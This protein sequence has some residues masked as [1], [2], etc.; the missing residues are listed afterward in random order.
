MKFAAL[1]TTALALLALLSAC[2]PQVEPPV[3]T[4]S[5]AAAEAR[6]TAVWA[7]EYSDI[8]V[9]P[10][11]HF[12]QLPNGMRYIL[13][14]N[15]TPR[16]T[17]LVR[18]AIRTGSLNE[19]ES[20][21]GF[22]HFVEHMAFNGSTNVSE[23]EMVRLLEREGLAFGADT[24][25]STSFET[26]I[27]KLDLPRNDPN[28][29]DTALM[30]MRETVSELTFSPEAVDRER[31][32]ILA[33]MRD[34]NSFHLRNTLDEVSFFYPEAH[35][36][37]RFPIGKA[38]TIRAATAEGLK[39][40]WTRE[41]VPQNTT[42]VVIGD[43]PP[44]MVEERIIEKFASWQPR[45]AEPQPGG[46]PVDFDDRARTDIYVDP[47]LSERVVA[48]RHGPWLDEPD[49][50]AQRK[51]NLLRQIGYN[52]INRRL[53][54]LA[55][56]ADPPFRGAG[57][58]TGNVFKDGRT[59]RLIVDSI[60]GKWQR[61]LPAAVREYRRALEFGFSDAE[62]AEQVA[63]VSAEIENNAASAGTR[64]NT[65][66]NHAAFALIDDETV[67]SDPRTVRER[68]EEFAPEIT[69]EA[70]FAALMRHA[71]P[72]DD[73][74][75]R[76]RGRQ[77]PDGGEDE[78]RATWDAAMRQPISQ[79]P[80]EE[81]AMFAYTD[82]GPAGAV[83]SDTHEPGLGIRKIRFANGVMLNLK[84]T[85][86]ENGRIRVKLNID[87]GRKLNTREQPLA[88]ELTPYLD[89]GGLG[90]HSEDELQSILAGKTVS[91][92][93]SA[94][95][96]RFVSSAITTPRDLE[97]QL[98]LMAA[99][100]IDPG[101]RREGEVQYWHRVNNY[102]KQRL[103]TPTAALGSEIGGI[104]SDNDPR[105]TLQDVQDYRKANYA[106]LKRAI[107]ERFTNGAI[108]IGI[109]G[110]F[111]EDRTIALVAATFGALP[112]REANFRTYN[113]QPPRTFT[114]DR[115]RRIVRHQGPVDQARLRISWPT[116]DGRDPL[117]AT[118]LALLE[119]V[120]RIRLTETLREALGKAY[121]PSASSSLSQSWEGFGTF[122]IN[123]SIDVDEVP[124]ARQAI[125]ETIIGLHAAPPTDDLLKR[126]RQPMLENYEQALKSNSGWLSLVDRAQ[127]E[128]ERI[129][130][131][132]SARQ[133][134][135]ALTAVDVQVM[136]LRYLH[137]DTALE[138]LVLPEEAMV[139]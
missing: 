88:T 66:L 2:A 122:S 35:Y 109:V 25:A 28:L 33:E 4:L 131:F 14:H 101:Y 38:E 118:R 48:S 70:A 75:L 130:R 84:R 110:D 90:K 27:Y 105:F 128:P 103:A 46:G 17:A 68:F 58:G 87:G 93:F 117:E 36:P 104:I 30:L 94:A 22:A 113:E 121:S 3:S 13:R 23:G 124:A 116:R 86:L 81:L 77:G 92:G 39:A 9:D 53:L 20:E 62:V 98:Q 32:V 129:A 72:L 6:K 136:A 137:L 45:P 18:M 85:D 10:A 49:T 42:I 107:S 41:Y 134:L 63:I 56:Q 73:P 11:Y 44:D 26:T 65:L 21:L 67:P 5:E 29:L 74:L 8:P 64:S 138:I 119:E 19:R 114:Q 31:G 102:F 61:A 123:A 95:V 112:Q 71:I 96:D 60:D 16:G 106:G 79:N 37:H 133:R 80:G 59:T 139:R 127:T 57:F 12:G 43:F 24:N 78:L 115:T 51:E 69:A 120:M 50:V 99:Y 132:L 76:F 100:V 83:V 54:H 1:S 135:L 126:A 97:L 34:R 47:A 111:D 40:F 89:E 55:R 15:A 108:E 7:F 82:F 125:R 91:V 52:I